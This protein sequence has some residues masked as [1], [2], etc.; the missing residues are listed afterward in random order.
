MWKIVPILEKFGNHLCKTEPRVS[1]SGRRRRF[2]RATRKHVLVAGWP[3]ERV[4]CSWRW[5]CSG[6]SASLIH[7]TALARDA[8]RANLSSFPS[9]GPRGGGTQQQLPTE[10]Q[11]EDE[12]ERARAAPPRQTWASLLCFSQIA[13]HQPQMT[14]LQQKVSLASTRP[15]EHSS[16]E[17]GD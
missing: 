8:R 5:S 17:Q 6:L 13:L 14:R 15:G 10:S 9:G 3:W 16:A 11:Q 4:S 12:Q 1:A 7:H 2:L